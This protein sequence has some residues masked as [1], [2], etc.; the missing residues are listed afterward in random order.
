[1]QAGF[2]LGDGDFEA[3][4]A[5]VTESVV[6]VGSYQ[7]TRTPAPLLVGTGFVVDDG[8]HVV[9]NHH[10][11]SQTLA[12]DAGE[13]LMIFVGRG[14]QAQRRQARVIRRDTEHDLALLRISGTPLPALNLGRAGR[15]VREGREIAFTGYPLGVVLG[16]YPVTHRGYIS[17]ITPVAIPAV[18]SRQL[19]AASIRRLRDPFLV[20]QLDA[21]AYPGNSGSP[22]YDPETGALLGVVN[23]VFIQASKEALLE[24]PSGITYAIPARYV[25][26]LLAPE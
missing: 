3:V 10:V 15:E 9:T 25:R 8:Y 2:C 23:K 17:S 22:L 20:Y 1:M 7:R 5:R 14:A 26:A 19:D 11:V 18:N 12:D 16:L 21:T 13:E 6:G 4:V 24:R